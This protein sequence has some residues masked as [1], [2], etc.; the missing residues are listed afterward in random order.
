MLVILLFIVETP[1]FCILRTNPEHVEKPKYP[2]CAEII[3]LSYD[4]LRLRFTPKLCIS[5]VFE[6]LLIAKHYIT[7]TSFS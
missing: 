1:T 3:L 4:A 7:E 2:L 6:H 5:E